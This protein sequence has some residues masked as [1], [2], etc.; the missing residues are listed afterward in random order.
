MKFGGGDPKPAYIDVKKEMPD[1]ET[2]LTNPAPEEGN[3][4][5]FNLGNFPIVCG[6]KDKNGM[7]LTSCY[8]TDNLNW[9]IIGNMNTPRNNF[10]LIPLTQ[11]I[12]LAYGKLMM[13]ILH[14]IS[15][16]FFY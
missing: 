5:L 14:M 10:A 7:G 11:S 8:T 1:C 16:V 13:Y 12:F 9:E 2:N 4:S 15:S 6:G 3:P